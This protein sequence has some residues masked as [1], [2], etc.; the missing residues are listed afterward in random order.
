MPSIVSGFEYDIF[1][2]Y[3]HNDN[4][5]GWV[6]EF[7]N[8]LQ[9]E[10]AATIK[11]PLSIYFDNNPHDGLLETHNVDKSLKGKLKCLIFI[12]IISQTYCDPKSFA[13]Q[14]EFCAFNNL[15]REDQFGRDI[16]L[17]SGNVASRILPVKIHDLDHEDR[18]IL[19][20]EIGGVLR[21]IEF[22]YKEPGVNR[23]LK[24]SDQKNDN[25]NKTD[26]R[27]Q[28]NKV[29]N[30]IKEII[31][32]LKNPVPSI[33]QTN[34]FS[35]ASIKLDT[36]FKRKYILG[37]ILILTLFV[38]GYLFF[39]KFRI[40]AQ[41]S[42]EVDKSV[43][44]LAFV[45]LSPNKDQEWFSDGL[46]E[47]ILNSL[48]NLNE[49]KVTART[50]SFYFKD[51]D[52]SLP[53]IGEK[54]G[55]AHVVEGSVR[56]IDDR[57]RITA[58]LIRVSDG[59]HIWSQT[60]D[61]TS[62]DLFKVQTDIAENIARQLIKEL[63]PAK[64]LQ[65]VTSKPANLEAYEY[66]LKGSKSWNKYYSSRLDNYLLEAERYYLKSLSSDPSY[67]ETYGGLAVTY[68]SKDSS[69]IDRDK[70]WNLSDSLIRI[71]LKLNPRSPFV[72]R[73]Y[74]YVLRRMDPPKLDSSFYLLKKAYQIDSYPGI[75][76]GFYR[77][78]GLNEI[79]LRFYQ[80]AV[81][82]DPLDINNLNGLARA[83]MN[84]GLFEE[85]KKNYEKILEWDNEARANSMLG[86]LAV[87]KGDI[88]QARRH[89]EVARGINPD[90]GLVINLEALIIAHEG[91]KAKA[92]GLSNDSRVLSLLG[93]KKEFLAKVDSI[94][95]R[96]TN[97]LDPVGLQKDPQY[98]FVRDEP[99]FKVILERV[100]RNY[101]EKLAKYGKLDWWE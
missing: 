43:A 68:L 52:V 54:L 25:L 7:V 92:L 26:Y 13:W 75:L 81:E 86:I 49:L 11:E 77:S 32:S 3:R 36:K 76:A 24:P 98:D 44:V 23:P 51:K 101:E 72:L 27:N 46:T 65:L 31:T 62:D 42:E 45:D 83:Q 35:E 9:E 22:I 80:Q 47:E 15:V 21:A 4:R 20:N 48:A 88:V 64:Q 67:A 34:S 60:Y 84:L 57:L 17:N 10:L 12:P 95:R 91:Q 100:R 55:V 56:R 99:E 82:I 37:A 85:A 33:A 61:R 28:V 39:P 59:F 87:L 16:K 1:I 41:N 96:P 90:F 74:S 18:S 69:H 5:S 29:A 53:E 89:L 78:V 66:Y 50:S 2:S 94:S 8:A 19:E 30:A 73:A 58:Q 6:T 38:S 14:H 71:G 93:M 40:A 97:T 70:Y 79:A 63:T